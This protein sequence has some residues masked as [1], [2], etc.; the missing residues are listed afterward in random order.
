MDEEMED[1][2]VEYV[3]TA[4]EID[5]DYEYDAVRFFDF[6]R[7]ESLAEARQAELWFDTA[8]TYP[9]SRK[10]VFVVFVLEHFLVFRFC[11]ERLRL[12]RGERR[13]ELILF[14]WLGV[15]CL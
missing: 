14:I 15:V 1:S 2:T 5:L 6:T 12:R 11:S 10:F 9:P 3:F 7:E 13:G 4:I 8:E